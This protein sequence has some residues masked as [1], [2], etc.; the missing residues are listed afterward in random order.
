MTFILGL[1]QTHLMTWESHSNLTQPN[2]CLAVI[3]YNILPL[4]S[5]LNIYP[6]PSSA[7]LR[8]VP[9]EQMKT[10]FHDSKPGLTKLLL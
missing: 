4:S 3:I 5:L 9:R 1:R 7:W 10:L 2:S 8:E 6:V